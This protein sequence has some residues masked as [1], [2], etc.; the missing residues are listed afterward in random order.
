M[1]KG[2]DKSDP[3]KR[4]IKKILG[5]TLIILLLSAPVIAK[6][7]EELRYIPGIIHLHS[8]ISTG[9]YSI[10]ELAQIT[11]AKGIPI[12]VITDHLLLRAEYGLSPFRRIIRKRVEKNSILHSGVKD[13]LSEIKEASKL[14][15]SLTIIPG[16]EVTPF[17]FWSGDFLKNNLTLHNFHKQFLVLGLE[18]EKDYLKMPV[19]GNQCFSFSREKFLRLLASLILILL[20]L[21]MI[22]RKRKN[23]FWFRSRF[24]ISSYP[25]RKSG[26]VLLILGL[27]FLFDSLL[28]SPDDPYHGE[29]NMQPYQNLINYVKE[30]NGLSFWS[31]PE[32][33]TEEKIRSIISSTLPY[34]EALLET[35]DYTGFASLYEGYRKVGGQEGIWDT[36][37]TEYCRGERAKPVWTIGEIDYHSPREKKEIDEVQTVFLLS[38]IDKNSVIAALGEGR[39]YALRRTKEYQLMLNNFTLSLPRGKIGKIGDTLIT[40][41][42][43]RIN[44][45]V[46]FSDGKRRKVNVKLIRSGKIIREF[47]GLTPM[48]RRFYDY[49]LPEGEKS[50]YR[51]DIET[52]YPHK[53]LTNPIFVKRK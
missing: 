47:I 6:G 40:E 32:A 31:A 11:Q 22:K 34:P 23:K 27:L 12:M 39:C 43:P 52:E 5:L 21:G 35:K 8:K 38:R 18:K 48:E 20:G 41:T 19:A 16:A 9:A 49:S 24:F 4:Y 25:Y 7:Q 26:I 1:R 36:V 28:L 14:Y 33:K 46:S 29:K 45:S 51:L 2:S 10:K 13:Y 44:F 50:Y 15:P 3:Y 30:R 17:Y 53:I 37:L 42:R